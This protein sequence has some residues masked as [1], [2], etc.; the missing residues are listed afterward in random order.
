MQ[1]QTTLVCQNSEAL[2]TVLA[3]ELSF[4]NAPP[5]TL[6]LDDAPGDASVD[7]VELLL[8]PAL[9]A[10][11]VMLVPPGAPAQLLELAAQ[12]AAEITGTIATKLILVSTFDS[13]STQA[14]QVVQR[15]PM[16]QSVRN[17]VAA[18]MWCVHWEL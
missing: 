14:S 18:K 3:N 16:V 13:A 8:L 2:S 5:T 11:L 15:A 7:T 17:T 6:E 10:Q 12:P 1:A 9:I 4:E